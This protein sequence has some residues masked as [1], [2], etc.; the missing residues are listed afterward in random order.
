MDVKYEKG[1]NPTAKAEFILDI[2]APKV[3]LR[4]SPKPFSP[5][6]DGVDDELKIDITLDEDSGIKSWRIDILDPAGNVFTSYAG[7]GEPARRIIWEGI[8]DQG[9]L[10]QSAEDYELIITI[11]DELGNIAREESTIPVDVLVIREGNRLK[12]IISSII[13]A[14]NTADYRGVEEVSALKNMKTLRRLA[15]IFKKYGNYKILIEGHAVSVHWDNP[16]RAEREQKE[17]LIPLSKARAEA[18]KSA[19]VEL[20]IDRN[21]ISTEGVGGAAPIVPH[22]DLE[23]RWKNRRVEFI[24][25]K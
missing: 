8:S 15:E 18:V 6:N 11:E 9:E 5:D 16:E 24:L 13:F 21:R 12:V 1:N 19:L 22:S 3:D 25:V 7:R 10:V 2:E 14:P 23:N 17:E 4:L 20:G